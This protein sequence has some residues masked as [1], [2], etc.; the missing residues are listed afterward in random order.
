MSEQVVE[1]C[2]RCDIIPEKYAEEFDQI[3]EGYYE[4][5]VM[6]VIN[7][8]GYPGYRDYDNAIYNYCSRYDESLYHFIMQHSPEFQLTDALE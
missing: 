4:W 5:S 2:I 3:S 7:A 8:P 1:V 6:P